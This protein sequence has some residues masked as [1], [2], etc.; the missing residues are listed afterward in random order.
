MIFCNEQFLQ[1]LASYF[2]QQL[3]INK[4]ILQRAVS[5]SLQC[6]TS[7]KSNKKILQPVTSEFLQQATSA[8]SNVCFYNE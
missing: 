1:R 4:G 7:A 3:T 5:D 2:F 6:T 8:T